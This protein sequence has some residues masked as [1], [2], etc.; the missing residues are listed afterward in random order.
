MN[1]KIKP[2]IVPMVYKL[3]Y[4]S[5]ISL[6]SVQLHVIRVTHPI[7][8]LRIIISP[9]LSTFCSEQICPSHRSK[10]EIYSTL[11]WD[12]FLSSINLR[13]FQQNLLHS[14]LG[15][16]SVIFN[17]SS[18]GGLKSLAESDI[19]C[20]E[21]WHNV[22][23]LSSYLYVCNFIFFQC[24]LCYLYRLSNVYFV[25]NI[26][27]SLT[28]NLLLLSLWSVTLNMCSHSPLFSFS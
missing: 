3:D 14:S 15:Y 18:F 25:V 19:E 13:T 28:Q 17:F 24:S 26:S 8:T 1:T 12:E 10:Y 4:V 9:T 27:E 11:G 6:R 2:C 22:I 7:S 16:T 20:T 21:L 23:H 5:L